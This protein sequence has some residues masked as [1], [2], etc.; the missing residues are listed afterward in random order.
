MAGWLSRRSFLVGK[1]RLLTGSRYESCVPCC[2]YLSA[3]ERTEP[4]VVVTRE[5]GNRGKENC[6][7]NYVF[8][9]PA[10]TDG[11]LLNR[12]GRGLP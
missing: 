4:D 12:A 9:Q 5:E 2:C 8:L 10:A 7:L 1:A 3:K 6:D 11:H